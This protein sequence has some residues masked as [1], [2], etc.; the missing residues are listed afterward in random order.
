MAPESY[1]YIGITYLVI[2]AVT[3]LSLALKAREG[4]RKNRYRE[5]PIR[6][7]LNYILH[8]LHIPPYLMAAYWYYDAYVHYISTARCA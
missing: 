8:A 3:A 7:P 6:K 2:A 1:L 4:R 5:V